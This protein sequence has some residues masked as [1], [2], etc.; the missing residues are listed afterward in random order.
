MYEREDKDTQD[1][2]NRLRDLAKLRSY[3][4][5]NQYD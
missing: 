3:I 2:T 4:S 5:H 1:G